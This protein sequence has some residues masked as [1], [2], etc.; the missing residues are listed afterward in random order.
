MSDAH[1]RIQA[2]A[3][4]LRGLRTRLHDVAPRLEELERGIESATTELAQVR[5][6][7]ETDREYARAQSAADREAVVRLETALAEREEL[8]SSLRDRLA[9]LG[10]MLG[11]Q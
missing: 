5:A 7:A 11:S 10:R 6:Q 1:V 8:R 2:S 4:R 3:E 9:E